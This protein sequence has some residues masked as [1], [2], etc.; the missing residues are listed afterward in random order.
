[1]VSLEILQQT[2]VLVVDSKL[3]I[4]PYGRLDG[5]VQKKMWLLKNALLEESRV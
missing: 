3:P 5:L 2:K 4:P 1:V